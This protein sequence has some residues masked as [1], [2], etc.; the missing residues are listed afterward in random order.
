[1]QRM[2]RA[3]GHPCLNPTRDRKRCLISLESA[4]FD[5]QN[6]MGRLLLATATLILLFGVSRVS[7]QQ[8][9]ASSQPA[10][11]NPSLPIDQRVDDLVSRMTMEEKAGQMVNTSAA[12][13]RLQV[14]AYNWWTEALH[15]I[16]TN[17]AT[18]F[19]QVIGLGATFD[20]PRIQEMAVS[21][22]VSPRMKSTVAT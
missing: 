11:L 22:W 16:V 15:G 7:G 10:Y 19:P 1:M 2:E 3:G 4:M 14:P 21:L 9:G 18:V 20:A 6:K 17:N 12:I 13:P 8:S 5:R